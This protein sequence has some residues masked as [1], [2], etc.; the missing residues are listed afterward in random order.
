MC[1]NHLFFFLFNLGISYKS[2]NVSISFRFFQ[3]SGIKVLKICPHDF[4]NFVGIYVTFPF[5]P[6]ILLMWADRHFLFA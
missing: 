6:L 3:F 5:L 4:L 2:A 1:L